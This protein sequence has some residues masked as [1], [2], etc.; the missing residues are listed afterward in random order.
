ML[1]VPPLNYSTSGPESCDA[2]LVNA[3]RALLGVLD[4][5]FFRLAWNDWH[6]GEADDRELE[7]G[8]VTFLFR[9]QA[10]SYV[11]RFARRVLDDEARGT[12]DPVA[13]GIGESVKRAT[14]LPDLRDEFLASSCA[15]ALGLLLVVV[16]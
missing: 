11:R 14:P 9:E 13:L 10:P 12:L 4:F 8:F 16:I 1:S 7:P 3:A 15:I 6:G 5:E 2:D